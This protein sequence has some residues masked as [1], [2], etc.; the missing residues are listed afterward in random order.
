MKIEETEALIPRNTSAALG[1][2]QSQSAKEKIE[3]LKSRYLW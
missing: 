3:L 2:I 1:I